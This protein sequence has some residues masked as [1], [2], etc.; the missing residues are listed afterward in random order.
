MNDISNLFRKLE[1]VWLQNVLKYLETYACATVISITASKHRMYL[2][3]LSIIIFG[4][5]VS[6]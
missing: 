4:S 2:G 5:V 3:G 6:T 1:P